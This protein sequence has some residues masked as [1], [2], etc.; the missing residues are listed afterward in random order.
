MRKSDV[1][2]FRHLHNSYNIEFRLNHR[3]SD[4]LLKTLNHNRSLDCRE[5]ECKPC[6]LKAAILRAIVRKRTHP[7]DEVIEHCKKQSSSFWYRSEHACD[8]KCKYFLDVLL[9]ECSLT[10]PDRCDHEHFCSIHRCKFSD[11]F[12]VLISIPGVGKIQDDY[13][14]FRPVIEDI[15]EGY[16]P[17][18]PHVSE[19]KQEWSDRYFLNALLRSTCKGIYA[20]IN[21]EEKEDEDGWDDEEDEDEDQNGWDDAPEEWGD[22]F[23]NP[24]YCMSLE[25]DL[26]FE[27]DRIYDNYD[28]LTDPERDTDMP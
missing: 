6:K 17:P 11:I 5:N 8:T 25:E 21:E 20:R 19:Q 4:R 10:K 18:P 28:I 15:F 27:S 1:I 13:T 7:H 14:D 26:D 23:V 12:V 9:H 2:V 16:Y 3:I 22:G 24:I